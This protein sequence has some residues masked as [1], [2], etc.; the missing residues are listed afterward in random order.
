MSEASTRSERARGDRRRRRRVLAGIAVLALVVTAAVVYVGLV[1]DPGA[2]TTPGPGD[3]SPTSSP[4]AQPLADVD[5]SALP[6]ERAAFCDRLDEDDAA[7]A[8]GAPV[9]G[10]SHYDSG[11]RVELDD[12]VRDVAHEFSC[13]YDAATTGA[14]ARAWVF[15]E[16]VTGSV[17]RSLVRDLRAGGSGSG[18]G[19][20]EPGGAPAYGTPTVATTCVSG[21]PATRVT[22]LRGLFGDAWLSCEVSLPARGTSRVAAVARTEQWCVR[23]VTTIGARP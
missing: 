20:R 22:S 5:L 21:R 15:A 8:L 7:T 6:V 11:D 12:G 4:T 23:V 18:G 2:T 16:P 17:A 13:G 10:T 19:C 9:T 1:R 3:A 14:S